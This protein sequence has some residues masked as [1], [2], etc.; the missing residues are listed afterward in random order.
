MLF[1]KWYW[2]SELLI[3]HTNKTEQYEK[4]SEILIP[5]LPRTT[6]L[7][8]WRNVSCQFLSFLITNV[9]N[10]HRAGGSDGAATVLKNNETAKTLPFRCASRIIYLLVKYIL[11][12]CNICIELFIVICAEVSVISIDNSMV[13]RVN[14]MG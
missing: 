6:Q 2:S 1:S 12:F 11:Y 14:I 5:N 4:T 7:A 10:E 13:I 8:N 9:R 3:K